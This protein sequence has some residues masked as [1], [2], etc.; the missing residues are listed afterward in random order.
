MVCV[1]VCSCLFFT[2]RFFN[3]V[4]DGEYKTS[5][6]V[7]AFMKWTSMSE[8]NMP[9]SSFFPAFAH[10]EGG[11]EVTGI[12]FIVVTLVFLL[13][14]VCV[15]YLNVKFKDIVSILCVLSLSQAAFFN[16]SLVNPSPRMRQ[17]VHS[18][19]PTATLWQDLT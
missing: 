16:F 5:K 4:Y 2:F 7:S 18:L 12:L 10:S 11:L 15:K 1:L 17:S 13:T 14:F 8:S 6:L 9:F 19:R 3:F